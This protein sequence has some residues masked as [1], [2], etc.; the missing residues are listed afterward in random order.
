MPPSIWP[1]TR[2]RVERP[3]DVLRRG[4]LHDLDQPELGVDVDDGAVGDEGERRVAVAL[5]VLVEV[6]GRAVVVLDGLVER[7]RRRWRRRPA[8]RRSPIESTTSAPSIDEP[9]RVD[10]VRRADVLEQPLAHGPAGGV[11][12]AAAHPRLAR[13]RRRAGRADRRCRSARARR[14]RRRAPCG[15]SAAAIVTK[16]CPTS[17][18]GEL[19]RGDAVGE[20]A[21]GR[22]VVVEALG[23]HEVLDRHAPAD[24]AP[25]VADVG[26]EPG[27]AGQAHRVAVVPADRR[28][29]AAA[30]RRSRGCSARPAR[31]SR[32]PAR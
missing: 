16:P 28:R 6:L 27:A 13:R 31:R 9:Q 32:R 2:Q 1:S 3:P 29:P 18:R 7:A 5:P 24:A 22:R 14:R 17:R 10:A 15:R 4:D 26:G 23:V 25:D 21:A 19:Q 12:G 30:A 8:M 20:P 11:D